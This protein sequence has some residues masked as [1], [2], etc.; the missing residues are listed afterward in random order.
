[1]KRMLSFGL[2]VLLC[3]AQLCAQDIVGKWQSKYAAKDIDHA[4]VNYTFNADKTCQ[5]TVDAGL[6][7]DGKSSTVV[8]KIFFSIDGN[9]EIKDNK[10]TLDYKPESMK[11]DFDFDIKGDGLDEDKVK[12]LR[13]LLKQAIDAKKDEMVGRLTESYRQSTLKIVSADKQQLKLEDKDGNQI[14]ADRVK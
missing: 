11:T 2:L 6:S 10:L 1:M 12:M 14:V 9:Y 8:F 5:L 7:K 13:P 4:V 3:T